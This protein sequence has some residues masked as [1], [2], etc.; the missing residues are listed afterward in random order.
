MKDIISFQPLADITL[1]IRFQS[2]ALVQYAIILKHFHI[3]TGREQ[4]KKSFKNKQ[5]DFAQIL[6]CYD[7]YQGLL[8]SLELTE[9]LAVLWNLGPCCH[10]SSNRPKYIFLKSF[11]LFRIKSESNMFLLSLIY[12]LDI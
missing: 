12:F 1:Q 7:P 8:A 5:G 4:V 11:I 9:I 6:R 3:N 2:I 10:F